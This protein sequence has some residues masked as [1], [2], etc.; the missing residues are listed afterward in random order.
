MGDAEVNTLK[1]P[2]I[3][4]PSKMVNDPPSKMASYHRMHRL[5]KKGEFY[6]LRL[7]Y[8]QHKMR[9]VAWECVR[10]LCKDHLTDD[11]KA[12]F[13]TNCK[14]AMISKPSVN[15]YFGQNIEHG[16]DN[17]S[18]QR[19]AYAVGSGTQS[20]GLDP[21]TNQLRNIF[22]EMADLM[23]TVTEVVR[24]KTCWKHA[25]FN[26]V[27]VKLY[28]TFRDKKGRMVK[29]D[30]NW[31]V[32]VTLNKKGV[33]MANNS[34][35]PQSPVA[36]FTFGDDKSLFFLRHRSREDFEPSTFFEV[37]QTMGTIFLLDG[38][39]EMWDHQKRV[40]RHCSGPS[41]GV[42]V[43]FMFRNVQKISEV[44]CTEGLPLEL[45]MSEKSRR[46]FED[47][48]EQF[49]S[50][51]YIEERKYIETVIRDMLKRHNPHNEGNSPFECGGKKRP[52][53]N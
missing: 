2:A 28:Y 33:P 16:R 24:Q 36:I 53:G 18:V 51:Y 20:V 29:K 32:D 30:T 49:G 43:S 48:E 3:R 17:G 46:M 6:S 40:W 9:R 8:S 11:L 25:Y 15:Y 13:G 34:Q 42:T 23:R 14:P 37:P 45:N 21:R 4:D 50:E 47:G 12:P 19:A 38:R 44:S 31:H 52:R 22:P 41:K 1:K 26:F 35:L 39:D 5:Q 10:T 7:R 27:S